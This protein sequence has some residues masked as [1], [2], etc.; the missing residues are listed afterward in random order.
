MSFEWWENWWD[1]SII[2]TIKKTTRS[3]QNI[4]NNLIDTIKD[5]ISTHD[6]DHTIPKV[7]ER[8][9][10]RVA[11]TIGR[12][13]NNWKTFIQDL[14]ETLLTIKDDNIIINSDEKISRYGFHHNGKLISGTAESLIDQVTEENIQSLTDIKLLKN[15]SLTATAMKDHCPENIFKYDL[16]ETWYQKLQEKIDMINSQ[17]ESREISTHRAIKDES[18][19]APIT[20][21]ANA[22]IEISM[23]ANSSLN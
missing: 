9:Y 14:F 23:V 19:K 1:K 22:N 5:K 7:I 2:K 21:W 6:K 11:D 3:V 4:G 10:N 15:L 17:L 16:W 18:N 20:V 13:Y 8:H 12:H